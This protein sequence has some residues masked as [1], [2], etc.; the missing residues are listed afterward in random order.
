MPILTDLERFAKAFEIWESDF[1]LRPDHY[2]T[3]AE[4]AAME[5]LPLSKARAICMVRFLEALEP[6]P[7][8]SAQ[9]CGCDPAEHWT[10]DKHRNDPGV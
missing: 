2:L 9:P 10:C 4:R 1:R 8:D 3:D 5:L 7:L 6:K